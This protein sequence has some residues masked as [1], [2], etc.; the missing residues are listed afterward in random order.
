MEETKETAAKLHTY[1]SAISFSPG[2]RTLVRQRNT[3]SDRRPLGTASVHPLQS[4]V[5]Y[6]NDS[7][8]TTTPHHSPPTPLSDGYDSVG[9][10]AQR[11]VP[12]QQAD[13]AC[14]VIGS[15]LRDF[16]SRSEASHVVMATSGNRERRERRRQFFQLTVIV[17]ATDG[18]WNGN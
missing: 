10:Y 5:N 4:Q 13:R 16:R 11:I 7:Y 8:L 17:R 6:F 12:F 1:T 2:L 9:R 14:S 3:G 15:G 18:N